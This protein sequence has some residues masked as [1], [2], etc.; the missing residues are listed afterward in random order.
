MNKL[1]LKGTGEEVA[2]KVLRAA[3]QL[4]LTSGRAPKS[5]AA[6]VSYIASKIT[7][8]YRTQREIAE[9]AQITEVTIRNR[10]KELMEQVLI[11]TSL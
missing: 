5:I 11:T 6:A 7:G 1:A 8:E 10:Y 4:K 3:K 2:H 9:A